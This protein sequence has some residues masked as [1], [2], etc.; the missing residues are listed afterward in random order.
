MDG[1]EDL[2]TAPM[3]AI[4]SSLPISPTSV[5]SASEDWIRTSPGVMS[6][7][8]ERAVM[9]IFRS[10]GGGE[11][12]SNMLRPAL[13][14]HESIKE[15]PVNRRVYPTQDRDSRG[16]SFSRHTHSVSHTTTVPRV[17]Q[18]AWAVP[19]AVQS[20]V[21]ASRAKDE[22]KENDHELVDLPQSRSAAGRPSGI[23]RVSDVQQQDLIGAHGVP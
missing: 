13:E 6:S 20:P 15:D 5:G 9:P 22:H 14:P 7:D 16:R 3:P 10:V 17:E 19:A 1:F 12:S 2:D 11:V 18:Q 4:P 21:E 8:G 23:V